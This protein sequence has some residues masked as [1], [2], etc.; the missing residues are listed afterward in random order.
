MSEMDPPRFSED[1]AAPGSLAFALRSARRHAPT[2]DE[3]RAMAAA[4]PVGPPPA[5]TTP[6]STGP[7]MSLKIG[8]GVSIL[9]LIGA[10]AGVALREA[11]PRSSTATEVPSVAAPSRAESSEPAMER[12]AAI[13][14][15]EATPELP[16]ERASA[17]ASQP[18]RSGVVTPTLSTAAADEGPSEAALLLSAKGAL[19]TNPERALALTQEHKRRFPNGK[20]AQERE[21]IAIQA[22]QK[23][24]RTGD[25]KAE[26]DRFKEE[27]PGSIHQPGH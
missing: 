12:I 19:A 26:S 15:S 2:S 5:P 21:V 22:L 17:S 14:A 11:A 13:S 7:S 20:L 23:L 16:E 4:L 6:L 10:G 3:L 8:V 24:G 27:H 18:A 1:A 9:A 25:A